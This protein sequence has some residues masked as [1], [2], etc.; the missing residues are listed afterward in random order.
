MHPER[1]LNVSNLMVM[2]T[3]VESVLVVMFGGLCDMLGHQSAAGCSITR[4]SSLLYR[5]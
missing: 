5:R 1:W 3:L 2:N 4:C